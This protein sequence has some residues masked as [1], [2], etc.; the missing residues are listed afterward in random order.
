M[1]CAGYI[2]I[3][4][5]K[6]TDNYS[7]DAQK[8]AIT[9]WVK[10]RGWELVNLYIDEGHSG[11]SLN[12]PAFQQLRRDAADGKFDRLARS[13][14]DSFAV[15]S[16]FRR[17]YGIKVFSVLEVSEDNDKVM[18]ALIESV[19][20][21]INEWYSKN[22]SKEYAKGKRERFMQGLHNGSRPFG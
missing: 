16:L 4:V 2:R 19:L 15:K 11:R 8:R 22:L 5:G 18:G 20:D 10:A 6:Q 3:S 17:D 14:A 12:R 9:D 13:M 21:S 1:R 7:V